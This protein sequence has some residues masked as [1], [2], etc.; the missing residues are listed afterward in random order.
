MK[1]LFIL[2][3]LI[4]TC[5]FLQQVDGAK[6]LFDYTKD[7]R[8]GNADW[9]IDTNY[10]IPYPT[11]PTAEDDWA[12]A[13]SAWG[14]AM[15]LQGHTCHTLTTTYGITYGNGSNPY[16]LS[17]YDVFVV[18]E[19]QNQFTS[20][21]KTAILNFVNAGGG[22]FM[23]ADHYGSDRNGSGWDSVE[24]WNDLGSETYFGLHFQGSGESYNNITYTSTRVSTDA[25]DP[26]TRGPNGDVNSFAFHGGT[27]VTLN[28][29]N[30]ST[31]TGHIWYDSSH[32]YVMFATA[33]YGSGKVCAV[34]DSSPADDGTG[35][36]G[37][38]LYD[39]WNEANDDTAFI[40]GM[41]WL[42][43]GSCDT[44]DATAPDWTV[45]GDANVMANPGNTV[46]ALDWDDATDAQ[47]PSVT[48]S[49][50]R[51]LTQGFTP[52]T[53]NRITQGL[54]SSQYTDTGLTNG[55]T[56][57][58]R[59]SAENCV[60]LTR[61]NNLADEV[62]AV[63]TAGGGG[64]C[65]LT[66]IISEYIEGGG[67]N[68]VIEIYNGTGSSV[69]LTGYAVRVYANG[70]S[71]PTSITLTGGPLADGDVYILANSG[72]SP[73]ILA[74]AD[75]TSGSLTHNGDD[76]IALFDGTN[77]ID[78]IGQIGTDPGSYWGTEPI[79]TVNHTLV[80]KSSIT[81]G[82]SNGAD[83]FDPATEWDAYAQDTISYLNSHTMD[84]G[85]GGC[86]T[87]DAT[88]PVFQG[89]SSSISVAD[90]ENGG[91][92]NISWAQ[93]DDLQNPDSVMY[94]LYRTTT[95]NFTP[96]SGN[97]IVTSLTALSYN[98]SGLTVGTTY[99]YT[100]Q[101]YNCAGLQTTNTDEEHAIP[102]DPAQA[103]TLNS[104]ITG[105]TEVSLS[106][107]SV[108]GSDE[109]RIYYS[110]FDEGPYTLITSTTATS[111]THTGLTN[112]VTY[113]YVVQNYDTAKLPPL[114][115]NSNQVYAVPTGGGSGS[116]CA[117]DLIIS[118][119]I[120]SG[121]EKYIE[122]Y[123]GTGAS[124]DLSNYQIIL[125]ANGSGT[126]TTTN[127]LSGS[128]PNDSVV[129]YKNS[130]SSQYPSGISMSAVNFNGDDA[131]ALYKISTSTYVDVIGQI[132]F[133][134]G[135]H[136]GTSPTMTEDATLV[137]KSTVIAGDSNGS[138]A[139]DP[140]TEWDGTAPVV[141]TNLGSHT[142]TC[143]GCDTGDVTAPDWA[144]SGDANLIVTNPGTDGD[145]NLN[146]DDASDTENPGTVKYAVYRDTSTGFV[147]GVSNRIAT[148]LTTSAYSDSGLTNGTPYY[149]RIETYN[150][151]ANTR[152]NTD[153]GSGTPTAPASLTIY[154]VQYTTTVGA[155]CYDSPENTNL[156]TV[157]GI[158]T[159]QKTSNSYVI[160]ESSG[161]WHGVYIWNST[162][163]PS[164]GDEITITGT[165]SE[166]N[167]LTEITSLTGYTVN[168]TGNTVPG[169]YPTTVETIGGSGEWGA[170]CNVTTESYE[171]VLVT[172][173]DV[174]VSSPT[175]AF[176][177][178]R[179]KDQG[180]T[181]HLGVDDTFYAATVTN[182]QQID[183]ITGVILYA[184]GY[185][186]LNPRNAGD[187]VFASCNTSDVTA[188][189]WAVSGD[190]N[191]VVTDPQTGGALELNWDDATDAENPG[192][193]E[194]AVYRATTTGFTP[195]AG[196][197]I[198]TGLTTSTYSDSGLTNG[199]TYFYRIET[200][201]CNANT[202]LNS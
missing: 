87:G 193:V 108:S 144:V 140:A 32:N 143:A 42:L 190:A 192:T 66:L 176:G 162:N 98:D 142:M 72:A 202:R 7:E 169:P 67:N 119:Y 201:N 29:G 4:L 171:G 158:V 94:A 198:A 156:V 85:S 36:S 194:Y 91:G 64:P 18:C 39:G 127:T 95:P 112:G 167:G 54:T 135:T 122:I 23:V 43:E 110:T 46:V 170:A 47:N 11:N 147:P 191:L 133:D 123:N 40:N 145:L 22:L 73:E 5:L 61:Y 52:G 125:Y 26:I 111:Y 65:A 172:L 178:W 165:V 159:A 174:E 82:D 24:I 84:C 81:A 106:W 104:P 77:N 161:P 59:V 55:T 183:Q 184:F 79:T 164:L 89:G 92:L 56:Y 128:L 129:V 175:S 3:I 60:P 185:Y 179:I 28:T 107:S 113:Y 15:Y 152:Y 48:Y 27:T 182:G 35:Y 93:A 34:G 173:Y 96:G 120:E 188:P 148:A 20:G 99:Y 116:G 21:E 2:S 166:Y 57:Y 180:G 199:I 31:A 195:A 153:E 45:S 69:T 6:I 8:A 131:F 17:N 136:W 50:Y 117:T 124:V 14:Y 83:A 189:D 70:S 121:S 75:Q 118:E 197:R 90:L 38:E 62:S 33:E 181:L 103:P 68:K 16:D 58:Y 86:D 126:P 88:A 12:G 97:L 1:K 138:D 9:V 177:Y 30:N 186:R 168:S 51:S 151:N 101:A 114:S 13:I 37:D 25:G 154:D 53:T 155:G 130:S 160:A 141:Y 10:P 74:L 102:T 196:N 80:R 44:G 19:P 157:T 41:S 76:A 149:Y 137:R 150:C 78:I 100:V 146:W 49:V 134:P 187:I 139:F 105:D 200:Y 163:N 132:G 71:T 63:P 109:Y 115:S